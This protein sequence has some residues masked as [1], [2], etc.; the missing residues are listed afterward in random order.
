V[1]GAQSSRERK[2]FLLKVFIKNVGELK[3]KKTKT[4]KKQT[5]NKQTN[6][7]KRT[8]QTQNIHKCPLAK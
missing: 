4:N 6:K 5:K 7:E 1:A 8:T 3:K 2:Y